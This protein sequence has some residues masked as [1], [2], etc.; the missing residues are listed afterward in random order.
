MIGPKGNIVAYYDKI[1]MFDVK[2]QNKENIKKVKHIGLARNLL[3][4]TF[5]GEG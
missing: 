5:H 1:K 4:S 2:L 3:Q